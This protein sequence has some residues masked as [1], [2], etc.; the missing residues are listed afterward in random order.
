M[1]IQKPKTY[2]QSCTRNLM[3]MFDALEVL[4]GR[5][6]LMI[7]YYLWTYR[8][9]TNTFKKLQRGIEG[10]SAKM[11]SKELKNLE[12]NLLVHR[13]VMDTHPI[14]VQYS[15]TEY[16]EKMNNVLTALVDWGQRHRQEIIKER[17]VE[18]SA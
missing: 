4:G 16:G 1:M 9:E 3:A 5:W 6:P 14:T 11:L 8:G 12:V 2:P 7:L 15:I 17:K 13:E 10:I 18:V